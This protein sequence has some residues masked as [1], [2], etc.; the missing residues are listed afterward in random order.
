MCVEVIVDVDWLALA[1]FG[2][3]GV[4]GVLFLVGLCLVFS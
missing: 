1:C 3:V 4:M 2:W